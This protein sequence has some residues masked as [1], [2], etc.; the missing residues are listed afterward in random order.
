MIHF[1]NTDLWMQ[2][3]V[4]TF[5]K[6]FYELEVWSPGLTKGQIETL[7]SPPVLGRRGENRTWKLVDSYLY[8]STKILCTLQVAIL[9]GSRILLIV[10]PEELSEIIMNM[11]CGTGMAMRVPK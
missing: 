9:T 2:T 7:Q 5:M 8:Q 6:K 3:E 1:R 10:N 4:K 11:S